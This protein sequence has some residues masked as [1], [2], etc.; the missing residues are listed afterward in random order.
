L[1]ARAHAAHRW[2][3]SLAARHHHDNTEAVVVVAIT[4]LI[5]ITV[6][7][8]QI[9]AVVVVPATTPK[10]AVAS[11]RT[12]SSTGV[13][14]VIPRDINLPAKLKTIRRPLRGMSF[15]SATSHLHIM[16]HGL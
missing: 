12:A 11:Y 5:V 1:F 7:R 6:R 3:K 14:A 16:L 13:C 8:Q 9:R 10:H 2:L 4:G 15:P